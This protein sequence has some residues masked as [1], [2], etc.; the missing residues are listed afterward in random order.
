MWKSFK[1]IVS[2]KAAPLSAMFL[3]AAR[4]TTATIH[5]KLLYVTSGA[6][7]MNSAYFP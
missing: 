1:E 6:Q 3:V 4:V 5:L 7:G 2:I